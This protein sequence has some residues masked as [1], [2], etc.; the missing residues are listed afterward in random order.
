MFVRYGD[1][2]TV[3]LQ[4]D[5]K[6][7]VEDRYIALLH[8]HPNNSA[9]SLADIDAADWLKAEILL[10]A[11]PDGT[12]HRY[13]RIGEA[14]IPLE[15]T[16]NPEYVAPADPLETAAADLAYLFQTWSE[17]GNPAEMVMRQGEAIPKLAD[18]IDNAQSKQS[19]N[20]DI[21]RSL[22]EYDPSTFTNV[23]EAHV[24]F[25]EIKLFAPL[26]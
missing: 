11:N 1:G 14:L 16:R 26:S 25:G 20:A 18:Y 22:G 6:K 15:P 19:E 3:T 4:D 2:D 24:A 5:Q 17:I 12:L 21:E 13:A 8:H 10:V 7:L 23:Q 9:A